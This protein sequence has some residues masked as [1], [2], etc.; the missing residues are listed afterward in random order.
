[1]VELGFDAAHGGG[2]AVVAVVAIGVASFRFAATSQAPIGGAVLL[3]CQVIALPVPRAVGVGPGLVG[4][5]G[6]GVVG[7]GEFV[8]GQV[9]GRGLAGAVVT[10]RGR[11][12]IGGQAF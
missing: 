6:V 5:G 3:C 2:E 1:M 12:V 4:G 11:G 8:L 10:E 9:R 7:E